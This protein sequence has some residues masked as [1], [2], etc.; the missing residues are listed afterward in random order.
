MWINLLVIIPAS[1]L[2]YQLLESLISFIPFQ[3]FLFFRKIIFCLTLLEL[4]NVWTKWNEIQF[5]KNFFQTYN[6]A[7]NAHMIFSKWKFEAWGSFK[8]RQLMKIFRKDVSEEKR[9]LDLYQSMVSLRMHHANVWSFQKFFWAFIFFLLYVEISLPC[10][11]RAHLLTAV[12]P[13]LPTVCHQTW[14]LAA[15]TGC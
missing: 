15:L 7:K 14:T 9:R 1:H 3:Y 11:H 2:L 4:M 10:T 5:W 13:V 6:C 8:V 12:S